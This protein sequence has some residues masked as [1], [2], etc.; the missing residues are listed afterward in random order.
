M[1][2][3]RKDKGSPLTITE[4]DNNFKELNDRLQTLEDSSFE[5][6]I[7]KIYL[8][9]TVANC[10]EILVIFVIISYRLLGSYDTTRISKFRRF[11]I[12]RSSIS[13]VY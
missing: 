10:Y 11:S 6:G 12:Q 5:G 1:I 3:Y 13:K 4:V 9:G 8:D 7:D 2:T